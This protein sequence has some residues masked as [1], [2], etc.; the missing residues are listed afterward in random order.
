MRPVHIQG[1]AVER[2]SRFANLTLFVIFLQVSVAAGPRLHNAAMMEGNLLGAGVTDFLALLTVFFL[3]K[4]QSLRIDRKC[5]SDMGLALKAA[6]LQGSVFPEKYI[7]PT[8]YH[9]MAGTQY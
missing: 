4:L 7:V 2:G 6:P 1:L 5:G 8:P 3:H 9:C